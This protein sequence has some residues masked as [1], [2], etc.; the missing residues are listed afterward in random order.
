MYSIL[1]EMPQPNFLLLK[2]LIR[3][4]VKIKTSRRNDLDTYI[5]SLRIASNVLLDPENKYLLYKTEHSKKVRESDFPFG[6][7]ILLVI[8]ELGITQQ[9]Q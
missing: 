8:Q 3:V 7:N 2:H 1:L 6:N 9:G 4:L 5:L